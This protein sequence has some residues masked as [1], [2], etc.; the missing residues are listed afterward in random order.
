MLSRPLSTLSLLCALAL[1]SGGAVEAANTAKEQLRPAGSS[2]RASTRNVFVNSSEIEVYLDDNLHFGIATTG[3]S[4]TSPLDNDLP[5]VYN[6]DP[7]NGI[8]DPW[9]SYDTIRIDGA[10][11]TPTQSSPIIT[12]PIAVSPTK[13]EGTMEFPLQGVSVTK[14]VEIVTFVTGGPNTAEIVWTVTNNSSSTK[15]IGLR[16]LLD[17]LIGSNDGVPVQFSTDPVV[18]EF[19]HGYGALNMPDFWYAYEY[20]PGDPRFPS[21]L[22]AQGTLTG[23]NATTP[24]RTGVFY[25]PNVATTQVWDYTFNAGQQYTGGVLGF[26]DSGIATWWNP[27]DYAVGETKTYVTYY[28]LARATTCDDFLSV[29]LQSPTNINVDCDGYN[30]EQFTVQTTLTNATLAN[31][32]GVV[33]NLNL[34]PGLSLVGGSPASVNVGTIAGGDNLVINWDVEVN[35]TASGTQTINLT[36][37][38]D[39]V[40]DCVLNRD[41][42]V[43]PPLNCT[44]TPSPT[45][46]GPTNTPTN[47]PTSTPTPTPT[48]PPTS[49]PTPTPTSTPTVTPTPDLTPPVVRLGGFGDTAFEDCQ[50]GTITFLAYVDTLG[51]GDDDRVELVLGGVPSGFELRDDF[52][53]VVGNGYY[54]A[55][56]PVGPN[57]VA[58]GQYL[59]EIYAYDRVGNRSELWPYVPIYAA[60]P[61]AQPAPSVPQLMRSFIQRPAPRTSQVER[62]ALNPDA[63]QIFLGGYWNSTLSQTNS[64]T[65]EMMAFVTDPNGDASSVEV[66]LNGMP[67]GLFLDESSPFAFG[68]GNGLYGLQIPGVDPLPGVSQLLLE[69]EARD[70]AGNTS[71]LWPYLSVDTCPPTPTPTPTVTPSPTPTNTPVPTP[72]PPACCNVSP[73]VT[74]RGEFV[75]VDAACTVAEIPVVRY[76]FD[77]GDDTVYVVNAPQTSAQHVYTSSGGASGVFTVLVT[78]ELETG[79]VLEGSCEVAIAP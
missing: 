70:L 72:V 16:M 50:G 48:I 9:S 7:V 44:P 23:F 4:P 17:T 36:V 62:G 58:G 53:G 5:M 6:Y 60:G 56:L 27:T 47:T 14:S 43:P 3:G 74:V 18:D 64:G 45:I 26:G 24:D 40:N 65:L 2:T 51:V 29:S 21:G 69:M 75:T 28:G 46:P 15:R 37:S 59:I 71:G 61:V 39:G 63:P 54:G 1:V 25:W 13:I 66:L 8:R 20:Q 22:V 42:T 55:T 78:A 31:V 52:D 32:N 76:T 11:F 10:D 33:A 34:P 73:Q 12:G 41:V 30:P 35:G 67:T 79:V 19:E 38:A 49:T 57:G 77:M 68:P